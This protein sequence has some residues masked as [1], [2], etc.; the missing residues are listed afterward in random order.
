MNAFFLTLSYFST[1]IFLVKFDQKFSG[2]WLTINDFKR[3]RR[4]SLC[5][6]E[7]LVATGK[8]IHGKKDVTEIM[9]KRP[10]G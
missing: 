3:C 9:E 2:L 10:Y 7:C 8:H 1:L 4:G 6:L 5:Y